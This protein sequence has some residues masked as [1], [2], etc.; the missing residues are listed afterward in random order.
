M[1]ND[2]SL[3]QMR[4]EIALLKGEVTQL[5]GL[6]TDLTGRV[7]EL[8]AAV[9]QRKDPPQQWSGGGYGTR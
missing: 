9:E 6:V 3:E 8:R 5:R 2:L 4:V 7:G 1:G